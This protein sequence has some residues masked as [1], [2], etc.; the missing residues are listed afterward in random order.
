MC[1]I[2]VCTA[3]SLH[4]HTQASSRFPLRTC[5][6]RFPADERQ[7]AQMGTVMFPR[8]F[9]NTRILH[10]RMAF[11]AAG[12]RPLQGWHADLDGLFSTLAVLRRGR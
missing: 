5:L 2:I 1:V 8:I 9:D 11:S 3:D 10:A 12:K 4:T 6:S 7:V